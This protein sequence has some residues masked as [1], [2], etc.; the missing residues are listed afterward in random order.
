MPGP[1]GGVPGPGGGC[2][3]KPPP[4]TATAAGGTHPTGMHSCFSNVWMANRDSS[5]FCKS[6]HCRHCLSRM[7]HENCHL[8]VMDPGFL[9]G[10]APTPQGS[11][12]TYDFAKF[13]QKLHEIERIW[14]R[15]RASLAPPLRSVFTSASI[16]SM[17]LLYPS[18]SFTCW[19]MYVLGK[20]FFS[21]S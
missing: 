7:L 11:A 4:G 17:W 14:T 12:P 20:E 2:L 9:R 19:R 5:K 8:S 13:S 18:I 10:G 1:V 15:E 3:V 6:L 21:F 16:R